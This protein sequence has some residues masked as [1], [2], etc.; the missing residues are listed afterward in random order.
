MR[1]WSS[2]FPVRPSCWF[3]D[4][5]IEQLFFASA[6]SKVC[7]EC[8]VNL[9]PIHPPICEI[10]FRPLD[11]DM[12]VCGDC[13]QISHRDRVQNVSAVSYT[14]KTKKV[15][16]RFKYL[17]DE[18]YAKYI[19]TIMC[20]TVEKHYSPI[21]FT[22]IT[23]VPLH[24]NRIKERG[25]NQSQLLAEQIGK[26]LGL[27][28]PS[29]LERIKASPPQANLGRNARIQS[30]RDCFGIQPDKMQL[31]FT[32]QTI[33]LVDDVYTTG[34]TIRECAKILRHAGAQTVYAVTFAR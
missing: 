12:N 25:F 17:G 28:A 26:S 22:L 31:D 1:W 10:C 7:K 34:T 24:Q 16:A 8:T 6:W 13:L 14:S 19:G 21:P 11:D 15:L 23:S 9:S 20:D 27:P 18:G 5:S 30:L 4:Q 33:L 3:C 29:L 2:L 32:S